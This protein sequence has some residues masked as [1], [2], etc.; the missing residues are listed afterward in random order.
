MN[1]NYNLDQN[2]SDLN[3]S[4]IGTTLNFGPV[5]FNLDYL[6]E[7]QHMGSQEYV[8]TDLNIILIIQVV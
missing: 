6:E 4:E 8:K 2:Y 1:Y 7:K 5:K 3:Y